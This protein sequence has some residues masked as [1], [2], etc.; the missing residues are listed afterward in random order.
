MEIFGGE[1]MSELQQTL[2]DI[3]NMDGSMHNRYS[4]IAI[5]KLVLV[6]LED[7]IKKQKKEFIASK[8]HGYNRYE[9][10]GYAPEGFDDYQGKTAIEIKFFRQGR[11]LKNVIND[12]VIR[13]THNDKQI[14]NLILIVL[15]P[16]P[17]SP[18]KLTFSFDDLSAAKSRRL[19]WK[20]KAASAHQLKNIDK[21]ADLL[22]NSLVRILG[23]QGNPQPATV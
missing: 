20:N 16:N 1:H 14:D 11:V 21:N 5:E 12:I 17:V 13:A 15:S 3:L 10:D 7:Y 23:F 8:S 18:N 6:M 22:Y 4:Y 2:N 19:N 9:F